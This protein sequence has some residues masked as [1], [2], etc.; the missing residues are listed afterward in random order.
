MFRRLLPVAI[1]V[2]IIMGFCKI[3]AQR[4]HLFSNEFG[5][6]LVAVGNFSII[7]IYLYF[8][9]VLLNR[10][11]VR[12]K[13]LEDSTAYA[14]DYL[15]KIINTVA[16]P[17]FVKDKG[18]RWVLVNSAFCEFFGR[19]A[20]DIIG[21]SDYHIFSKEL[22]DI[23]W[24]K[25]EELFLEGKDLIDQESFL[26]AKGD[27]KIISTK[28]ALYVDNHGSKFIVG[29]VR[30]VTKQVQIQ[31]KIEKQ[32]QELE[33]SLKEALNSRR[34]MVSMLDDNNKIREDLEHRLEELK[35]SQNMLIH[36]EKLASLGRLVSEITHEINN[37]LMIISGYAQL[38]M[39]SNSISDE[40]KNNL[41]IIVQE[42]QRAKDVTKRILR[43]SR[44][45][46]G[47]S[48]EV[49]INQCLETVVSIVEKQFVLNNN[50]EI[51]RVYSE[52]PIYVLLDEQQM[53]E[54]FMNLLN[55]AKESMPNNGVITV[56]TSTE[57]MY[58]R[59]DFKDTGAGM[60]PEVMRKITEPFFTTK[61]TGTGIG[62]GVCYAI[63]KAHN[64]EL[65]YT[66]EV[67]KGTV[68]TVWLPLKGGHNG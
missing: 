31:E 10:S 51:K 8:L 11:D 32:S 56:T 59:I 7:T 58:L 4:V 15:E 6:C 24:E 64:G 67:G 47:E 30:D 22:A 52:K 40:Q 21:S 35:R 41:K 17:M 62:L 1:A 57:G 23:S 25:D 46:K 54:V 42:C 19:K 44:S 34:I 26:D 5:V 12:R 37:P 18:H 27:P 2:P 36:S 66:S 61:E 38:S 48:K 60:S 33:F 63:I 55:N 29:V 13:A 16:D 49:E 45:S 39:I 28:R 68:V 65:T 20:E 53:H 9:S 50:I 3:L 14:K 43:F